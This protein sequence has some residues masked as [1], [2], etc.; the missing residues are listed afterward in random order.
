MFLCYCKIDRVGSKHGHE[1]IQNSQFLG[2]A[3]K[4]EGSFKRKE[5]DKG[6]SL[7]RQH[8]TFHVT[9]PCLSNTNTDV[10]NLHILP[11]F[12]VGANFEDEVLGVSWDRLLGDFLHKLG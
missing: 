7:D 10:R 8:N 4:T 6:I 11:G 5:K 9:K 12:I 3:S 2:V 1:T